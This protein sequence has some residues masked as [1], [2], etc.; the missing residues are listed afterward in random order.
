MEYLPVIMMGG[1][2]DFCQ[3]CWKICGRASK[4]RLRP[5]TRRKKPSHLKYVRYH[6]TTVVTPGWSGRDE[7]V[8]VVRVPEYRSYATAVALRNSRPVVPVAVTPEVASVS[9]VP[10]SGRKRKSPD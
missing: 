10:V 1:C 6:P 8:P 2:S 9:G 5:A 3:R 4:K 7:P